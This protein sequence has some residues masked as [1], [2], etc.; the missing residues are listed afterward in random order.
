MI[1][2]T[3]TRN[4]RKSPVNKTEWDEE[5]MNLLDAAEELGWVPPWN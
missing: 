4:F 3:T 2:P 1:N 5:G